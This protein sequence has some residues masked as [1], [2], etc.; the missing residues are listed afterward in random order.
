MCEAI[1]RRGLSDAQAAL[2]A[3]ISRATLGR[4]KRDHEELEDWLAMAREEYRDAKLAIVDEAK[5]KDGRP[6][7]RAAVWALEKAF[8]EDYGRRAAVAPSAPSVAPRPSLTS[9]PDGMLEE[10]QARNLTPEIREFVR[11]ENEESERLEREE[12]LGEHS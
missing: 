9:W 3:G 5:T 1:R 4:W 10:W 8:P 12:A 6:E 2:S 11:Q 7:W